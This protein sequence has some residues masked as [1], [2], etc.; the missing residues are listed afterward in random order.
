MYTNIVSVL[1]HFHY[2]DT[3]SAYL[4]ACNFEQLSGSVKTVNIAAQVQ[5]ADNVNGLTYC[6]YVCIRMA[7]VTKYLNGVRWY[8]VV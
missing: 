1:H 3:S 8:S 2:I 6:M 4:T 5:L 7:Y